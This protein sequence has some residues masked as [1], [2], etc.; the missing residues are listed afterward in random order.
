MISVL[1]ETKYIQILLYIRRTGIV[2]AKAAPL[3]AADI[4]PMIVSKSKNANITHT[5]VNDNCPSTMPVS[6]ENRLR[7]LPIGVI[8]AINVST[9]EVQMM[10]DG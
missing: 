10:N 5:R 7:I 9:I 1:V 6:F 4:D 8:W 2:I 3:V